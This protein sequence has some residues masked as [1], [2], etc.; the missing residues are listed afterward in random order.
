MKEGLG[1]G[2]GEEGLVV[3]VACVFRWGWV[4]EVVAFRGKDRRRFF[5]FIFL[6]E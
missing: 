5:S 4:G 1:L 3:V 6:G 2:E